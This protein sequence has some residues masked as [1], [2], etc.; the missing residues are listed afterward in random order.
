MDYIYGSTPRKR[1]TSGIYTSTEYPSNREIPLHNENAYANRWPRS[2]AFCCVVPPARGGETPLADLRD[3]VRSIGPPL[4]DRFESVGVQYLRHFHDGFDLSWKET[5]QTAD[6]A[7]VARICAANGIEYEW[8]G[9]GVK[10]LGI[11]QTCQGVAWHPHSGERLFFNQA[12]L[13]HA[14]SVGAEA[15]GA[16]RDAFGPDRLPRHSRYGDGSEIPVADIIHINKAF[17]ENA[18]TFQWRRGDVVWI[19]NMQ[20]AHGRKPFAGERRILATLLDPSGAD[21]GASLKS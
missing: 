19:D 21:P 15:L 12:H 20:V 5:F 2:I 1:V 11:R 9:N 7:E 6:P 14:T 3:V 13:F 8:F 4:M 16:M 18:T 10:T 17:Q